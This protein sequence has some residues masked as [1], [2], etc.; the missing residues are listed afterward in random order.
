[1]RFNELVST[2]GFAQQISRRHGT[3]PHLKLQ[4]LDLSTKS[5]EL[6]QKRL[7]ETK[8]ARKKLAELPKL[9]SS[10]PGVDAS[11]RYKINS[12]NS[13][14]DALDKKL[15]DEWSRLY[16]VHQDAT[17]KPLR[18]VTMAV[19]SQNPMGAMMRS[20]VTCTVRTGAAQLISLDQR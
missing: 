6:H 8:E 20:D 12:A 14:R 15:G 7:D 4:M 10:T 2:L 19:D 13:E 5:G 9:D 17:S 1:M 18:I 3:H 16:D 11:L